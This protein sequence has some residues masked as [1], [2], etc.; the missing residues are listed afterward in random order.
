MITDIVSLI[1]LV[2]GSLFMLLA[3]VGIVRMPD[4]FLRM[5]STT[6]AATLG[7]ISLLLAMAIQFGSLAVASRAAAIIFFLLLTTPIAAHMI[8]R[9]AY[10]TGVPLITS[11]RVDELS[12]RYDEETHELQSPR[13]LRPQRQEAP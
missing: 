2:V 4:L 3:A 10:C 9:A 13:R 5:S 12:G 6:K 1:F 11:T 8:G 7:S